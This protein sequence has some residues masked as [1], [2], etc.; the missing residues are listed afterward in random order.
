M[1]NALFLDRDG[2]LNVRLPGEYV[3][4]PDELIL[5]PGFEEAMA[6]LAP[7]FHPIVVVTNQAGIGK[8]LMTEAQLSLIHEKLW[9]ATAQAGG[10]IDRI[11]HCPDA[12]DTG[13][14]CRKPATGMA[15]VALAEFPDMEF[16]RAWMVGDTASDMAFG[17]ALGMKT[18]FIQG[19]VT[20]EKKIE[21]TKPHFVYASLMDFARFYS[22]RR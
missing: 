5:S 1:T 8:G 18:V 9:M 19:D 7:L 12:P 6:L 20:E 13:S 16:S 3:K 21:T 10:R 17:H 2:V 14:T 4:H 15:W 22:G 11:Y